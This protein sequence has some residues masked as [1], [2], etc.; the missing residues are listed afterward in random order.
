ME[1]A[2]ATRPD[3]ITLDRMI[4]DAIPKAK[5][6][7]RLDTATTLTSVLTTRPTPAKRCS[8]ACAPRNAEDSRTIQERV[9]DPFIAHDCA[10]SRHAGRDSAAR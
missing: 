9:I 6:A 7:L 1:A 10:C 5:K 2:I 4:D 3:K 8:S